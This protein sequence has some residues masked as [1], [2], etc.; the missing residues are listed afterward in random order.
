[1]D[2]DSGNLIPQL[3]DLFS[4]MEAEY[5]RVG[6]TYGFTCAGCEDNCCGTG[7]RHHTR[8]EL[9]LLREGLNTLDEKTREHLRENSARALEAEAAGEKPRCPLLRE[10]RCSLYKY[11]PMVCR[12][13][14]LPHVLR[15]PARGEIAGEGCL[16]FQNLFPDGGGARIDRTSF[17]QEFAVL[18]Q[19]ARREYGDER[20]AARNIPEMITEII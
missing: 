7:F 8:L 2:S 16:R 10:N 13:H 19:Q 17:Y 6:E 18:E 15:N 11:R 1:M 20:I 12:L 3:H 9:E 5:D 14:G 4:R